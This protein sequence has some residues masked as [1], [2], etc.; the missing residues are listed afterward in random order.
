MGCL[1]LDRLTMAFCSV[2]SSTDAK[3]LLE[4][5]RAAPERPWA[6]VASCS[7]WHYSFRA[8]EACPFAGRQFPPERVAEESNV[9]LVLYRRS[10]CSQP[11]GPH[12]LATV[13]RGKLLVLR[14]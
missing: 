1:I 10:N 3:W 11:L 2:D 14:A 5:D 13:Q 9:S 6:V 4:G 12:A 8:L 7:P